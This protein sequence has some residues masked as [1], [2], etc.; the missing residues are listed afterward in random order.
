MRSPSRRAFSSSGNASSLRTI[1]PSRKPDF[2]VFTVRPTY[3]DT[4]CSIVT[5]KVAIRRSASHDPS[6]VTQRRA[7]SRAGSSCGKLRLL[8]PSLA[9]FAPRNRRGSERHLSL[10]RIAHPALSSRGPRTRSRPAG[11]AHAPG[12]AR[13]LLL[14]VCPLPRP[15]QFPGC[16]F[17]TPGLQPDFRRWATS[18]FPHGFWYAPLGPRLRSYRLSPHPSHAEPYQGKQADKHGCFC[19]CR[20]GLHAP[21]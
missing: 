16:L 13:P 3:S 7:C 6:L 8:P 2:R 9:E 18:K 11:A 15:P 17:S 1:L 14:R 4:N 12:I 10:R 21:P 5:E 19:L 20:S